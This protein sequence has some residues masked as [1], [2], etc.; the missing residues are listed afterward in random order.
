M[1]LLASRKSWLLAPAVYVLSLLVLA[2]VWAVMEPAAL[3]GAFDADGRSFFEILT[4]PFYA[5]IV[6]LVWLACPF[7][8]SALRRSLLCLA[9]SCVA[10]MAVCKELDLHIAVLSSVYPDTVANFRGTPFKMRFLT[11]GGIP[12]GAKLMVISYFVLFFGVFAALFAAYAVKF[13][14]GVFRLHPVA[15]TIGCMGASGVM[16]QICDRLP[17]WYRHT[18]GDGADI[19]ARA[20]SACTAFEEGGEMM[21]AA[22]ALLAILQAHELYGSGGEKYPV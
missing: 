2:C 5:L 4:I 6:P 22:F 21:L 1:N 13:V 9:V 19:S 14:K 8:G 20:S 17:A 18:I 11:R 10:V 3:R 7:G 16:V 15:W 12:I